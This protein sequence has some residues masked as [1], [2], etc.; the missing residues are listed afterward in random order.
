MFQAACQLAA[1]YTWP[2]TIAQRHHDGSCSCGI[3]TI[4]IVNE[5]GWFVTAFHIFEG[6]T[7]AVQQTLDV[8]KHLQDRLD[9]QADK[10]LTKKPRD[11]KLFAL[12]KV[13]DKAV[14][15]VSMWL[16]RDG[17][18]AENIGGVKE[19]DLAWGKLKGFDKSWVKTYPTFKN[20]AVNFDTGASLCKLGFPLYEI[21]PTFNA[22]TNAFQLPPSAFPLFPIEGIFTRNLDIQNAAGASVGWMLETSSPG[23]RGQSGGPI[24]DAKG[25][26]WAL[27][28][29]TNHHNLG[30]NTA[31]PQFLHSGVGPHA[32]SILS[33]LS[34][35]GVR[36]QVSTD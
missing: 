30:F 21:T 15:N 25:R 26:I 16:G 28:C 34:T 24:F 17:L 7:A 4:T 33:A 2:T 22:A 8:K 29:R 1:Q 5:E 6:F 13:N 36:V 27:Q 20:P 35:A 18:V 9:I 3:G 23:L 14:T 11:K 10:S 31:E 32:K 12:G 19:L